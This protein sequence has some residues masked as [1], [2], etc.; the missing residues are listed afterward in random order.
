MKLFMDDYCCLP[1][2]WTQRRVEVLLVTSMTDD[3]CI[4]QMTSSLDVEPGVC[5]ECVG[6]PHG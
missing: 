3:C 6:S 4:R 5:N 2:E 1:P